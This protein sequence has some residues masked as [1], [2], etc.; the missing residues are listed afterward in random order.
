MAGSNSHIKI[1]TLNVNGLN[2]PIKRHRLANWI[3][4]QNPLVCCIQETRLTYKDTQRLKK[5]K[6]DLPSKWRIKKGRGCNPRLWW[7]G[8]QTIK[9]QKRQRRTLHNGKRI[10]PTKNANYPKY[11]WPNTGAP[12]YIKQF[13]NDLK[14]DWDSHAMRVRD[15]NTPLSILDGSMR[16]KINKDIQ[17][18]NAE[19]D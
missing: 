7:N 17:D 2:T 10:N 12:R 1:V 3:K 18:L 9:H 4:S 5:M 13:L 14:R 15:F 11:I 6:E 8:L 16:Q 19:L